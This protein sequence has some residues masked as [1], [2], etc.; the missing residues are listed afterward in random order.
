MIFVFFVHQALRMNHHFTKI[1]IEVEIIETD[2]N[3]VLA[4]LDVQLCINSC[5]LGQCLRL[6]SRLC[7]PSPPFSLSRSIWLFLILGI[8]IIYATPTHRLPESERTLVSPQRTM[9]Q[10]CI[11]HVRQLKSLLSS[12]CAQTRLFVCYVVV[13]HCR[14]IGNN[15]W[16]LLVD[17]RVFRYSQLSIPTVYVSI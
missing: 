16:M 11:S 7:P 13:V 2:Y 6:P 9:I 5:F 4:F 10:K 17:L 8:Y 15:V 14:A 12:Y 1:A 3:L